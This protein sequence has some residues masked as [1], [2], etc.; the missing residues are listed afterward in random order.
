MSALKC[1]PPS[2]CLWVVHMERTCP[3]TTAPVGKA[4]RSSPCG[5]RT[6]T[7]LSLLMDFCEID[8]WKDGPYTLI[9]IQT[10][11]LVCPNTVVFG[12]EKIK[13]KQVIFFWAGKE[14]N[15]S[16]LSLCWCWHVDK[17]LLFVL[18]VLKSEVRCNWLFLILYMFCF[19]KNL[20]GLFWMKLR[21]LLGSHC[22]DVK[23]WFMCGIQK[24]ILVPF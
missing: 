21:P 13:T 20:F 9:Y 12:T 8:G 16:D 11:W 5:H 24:E 1:Y 19:V 23:G 4:V 22:L 2:N 3:M 7:L 17:G 18:C 6:F 14:G 10:S 15:N